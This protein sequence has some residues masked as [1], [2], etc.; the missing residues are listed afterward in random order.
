MGIDRPSLLCGQVDSL[1]VLDMVRWG[2]VDM[3][4]QGQPRH[5]ALLCGRV[6]QPLMPWLY[7]LA[8]V[9][10]LTSQEEGHPN[11]IFE[12]LL[13]GTPAIVMSDC[14]WL[15]AE[16]CREA[17][18]DETNA[19]L[20]VVAPTPEAIRDAVEFARAWPRDR[21]AKRCRALVLAQYDQWR[22]YCATDRM[23]RTG[24]GLFQAGQLAHFPD[25]VGHHE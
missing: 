20:Q 8:E 25:E 18:G 13:C 22:M 7:N 17:A 14:E 19:A 5:G 9:C 21:L 23:V 16:A 11:C 4:G 3:N 2:N 12:A 6:P 1:P 15:V 24:L 10:V